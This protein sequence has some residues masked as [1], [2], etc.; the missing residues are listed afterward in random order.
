MSRA[1]QTGNTVPVELPIQVER[2]VNVWHA[3]DPLAFLIAPVL[4]VPGVEI[5]DRRL[6]PDGL[7]VSLAA[8]SS[9][10]HDQR[11][12]DWLGRTLGS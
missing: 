5:E 3:L 7:G 2:W 1:G 11:F 8:H 10:W 6:D 4:S 9:Y 12:L